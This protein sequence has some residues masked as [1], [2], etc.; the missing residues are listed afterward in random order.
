[1]L[2]HDTLSDHDDSDARHQR[3]ATASFITK[4]LKTL[5]LP[6]V[7]VA[8]TWYVVRGNTYA[9]NTFYSGVLLVSSRPILSVTHFA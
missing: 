7:D 4:A 6:I 9:R 5:K 1:M 3:H 8:Y 2:T